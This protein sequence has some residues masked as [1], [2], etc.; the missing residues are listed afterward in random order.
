MGEA[1]KNEQPYLE[2]VDGKRRFACAPVAVLA[3]IM[4]KQ[5]EILLLSHPR[6]EGAWE[7]VNGALEAGESVLDAALR[8][9]REEAGPAVKVRPLGSVH[10]TAFHYDAQGKEDP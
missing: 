8:E 10:V 2:T 9:T 1:T 3:L 5:E 6:R 7:V 4:N